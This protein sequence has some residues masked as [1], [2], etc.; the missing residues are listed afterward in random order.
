MTL[1]IDQVAQNDPNILT[2]LPKMTI[3]TDQVAQND[4]HYWP[5]GPK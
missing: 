5:S 3:T 2:K 1:T 4:P